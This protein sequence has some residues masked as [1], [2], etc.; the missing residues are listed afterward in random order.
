MVIAVN[1]PE[2]VSQAVPDV[3]VV[4]HHGELDFATELTIGKA[5]TG[6]YARRFLVQIVQVIIA[7]VDE[8]DVTAIVSKADGLARRF[9]HHRP[10]HL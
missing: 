4:E 10:V 8:T 5:H 3:L 7:W 1:Q 2:S 6:P 9:A